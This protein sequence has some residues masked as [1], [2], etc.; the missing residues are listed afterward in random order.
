M[1]G[2]TA[3]MSET[4]EPLGFASVNMANNKIENGSEQSTL[5]GLEQ[6]MM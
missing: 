1:E 5:V 6:N 4:E 2:T 3:V